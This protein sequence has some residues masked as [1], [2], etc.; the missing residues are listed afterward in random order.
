MIDSL[1]TAALIVVAPHLK[2]KFATF[3]AAVY[4]CVA[5]VLMIKK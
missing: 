4:V 2:P 5:L 3:L 1:T